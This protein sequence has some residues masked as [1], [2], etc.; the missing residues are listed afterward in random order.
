[1]EAKINRTEAILVECIV[2]NEEILKKI[3]KAINDLGCSKSE[4]SALNTLLFDFLKG[5]Y[6]EFLNFCSVTKKK[7]DSGDLK[8]KEELL[9]EVAQ[10]IDTIVDTLKEK[11]INRVDNDRV[12]PLKSKSSQK[13]ASIVREVEQEI[14]ENEKEQVEVSE[15][16]PESPKVRELLFRGDA[17]KIKGDKYALE[18]LFFIIDGS[19]VAKN[20]RDTNSSS[21]QIIGKLANIEIL[22][23]KLKRLELTSENYLFE[24]DAS[25]L[26]KIDRKSDYD[27]KLKNECNTFKQTPAQREA[28]AMMLRLAKELEEKGKCVFIVSNDTFG[29]YDPNSNK[30]DANKGTEFDYEWVRERRITF[31]IARGIAILDDVS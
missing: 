4:K 2:F 22:E 16:Q 28:D 17:L 25:L 27:N 29:E 26:Y 11:N 10:R 30:Y 19:N 31:Q 12:L 14:N 20:E 3:N 24:C 8:E 9:I 1:M 15:S 5:I 23:N 18:E 21:N 6:A 7:G 13:K